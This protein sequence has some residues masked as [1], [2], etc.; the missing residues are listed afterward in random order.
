M[1]IAGEV[2][3]ADKKVFSVIVDIENQKLFCTRQHIAVKGN[4]KKLLN[5]HIFDLIVKFSL[6]SSLSLRIPLM[7]LETKPPM[8]NE[9]ALM[10]A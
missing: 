6:V 4:A 8:A 7:R 1:V 10:M 9:E 3:E 5:M 2:Y